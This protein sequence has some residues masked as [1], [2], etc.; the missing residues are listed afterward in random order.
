MPT[1]TP[2]STT[3]RVVERSGRTYTEALEGTTSIWNYGTPTAT[4]LKM[5]RQAAGTGVPVTIFPEHLG[6]FTRQ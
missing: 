6:G 2:S 4:I 3:L 5:L 1:Q